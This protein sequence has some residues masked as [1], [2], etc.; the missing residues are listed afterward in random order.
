MRAS[1]DSVSAGQ[2]KV[3]EFFLTKVLESSYLS[4]ARIA[5]LIDVSHSTVVR[6]AQTLGFDGF[7]EFQAAL[8]QELPGRMTNGE[9]TANL[10]QV[11]ATK[12]IN[13]L[14]N[15]GNTSANAILQSMMTADIRNIESLAAQIPIADFEQA[16]NWLVEAPH[17]FIIGLRHSAPTALSFAM[18]LRRLRPNC[19]LLQPGV[20]DLIEQITNIDS[21]DVL[22][23]IC[24][25]RYMRDTLKVMDHARR[26]G[27]RVIV[28]TDT[29][30]SPAAR[31]ADLVFTIRQGVMF[32]GAAA[33]LFS[34]LKAMI[35]AIL[36]RENASAQ[37]RLAAID[38]IVD[39]FRMFEPPT[40]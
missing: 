26:V 38:R 32:Y 12:L 9:P 24:F 20:G 4:A 40:E 22:F 16:I 23:A 25:D 6:T 19:T 21:G 18:S 3:L 31:R 14:I 1:Y 2:Q 28:A 7:P 17:V 35:A 15:Q 39:E 37:Q 5:E 27:A 10:Y 30:V 36:I 11:S 8:Q 33:G 29:P 13:D 34:L